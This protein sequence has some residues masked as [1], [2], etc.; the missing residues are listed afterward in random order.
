MKRKQLA[1]FIVLLV[2][3]AFSA[4]ATYAFFTDELVATTGVPI[5]DLG[6]SNVVIGLANAGIVLVV[7][8]LLG[9][10]GY[11]FARKLE[12]P[13]IYSD[14]GNWRRWFLAPFLSGLLCGILLILRGS[15]FCPHQ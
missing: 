8:G 15:D 13:G 5:P 10:A 11:W 9:F 4:F 7:Y 14:D 3:Y 6:V 12:L 2:A 1:V